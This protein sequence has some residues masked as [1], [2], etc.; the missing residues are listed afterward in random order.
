[1]DILV[2]PESAIVAVVREAKPVLFECATGC[3][4]VYSEDRILT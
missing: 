4:T 2:L 1:M 3:G